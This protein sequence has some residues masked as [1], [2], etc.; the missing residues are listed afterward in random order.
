M[1]ALHPMSAEGYWRGEKA[2][3][4][5]QASLKSERQARFITISRQAGAGGTT[6]ARLLVDRL[7]Q[8]S[9]GERWKVYDQELVDVTAQE[10]HLSGRLIEDMVDNS[11]G[12][13]VEELFQ[14]LSVRQEEYPSEV[15]VYHRVARTIR[16]LAVRG[17]AVIVGRGGVYVTRDVSDGV[18]VRLVAPLP[19]RIARMAELL[20]V[21]KDEAAARV[22]EIDHR[23]RAFYQKYWYWQ[24]DVFAPELF[25]V[26]INMGAMDEAQA[27]E[28]VMALAEGR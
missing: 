2:P 15:K 11:G 4:V 27:L 7:N 23:R 14:G 8:M 21:S 6:L 19:W 9:G 24:G 5:E 25:T 1:T 3:V 18:H 17:R 12:S 16:A 13:W 10:H 20:K 26:T 28:C 22:E